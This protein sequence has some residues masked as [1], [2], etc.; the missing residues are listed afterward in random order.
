MKVFF[1][2]LKREGVIANNPASY[3]ES[4]K[5]WQ[6]LPAVLTEEEM[7]NILTQPNCHSAKGCRDRAILELLYSSGVRI[8]ELCGL[9]ICDVDDEYI[10]VYGKGGKERLVPIGQNALGAIDHY[11]LHYRCRYD[12]DQE[13]HLFLTQRGS[14]IDRFAMWRMVKSYALKAGITKNISPHTFRHSFATHLLDH[15]ADLRVIQELLGHSSINSTDRYTHVSRAQLQ[16]AFQ[17]FHPRC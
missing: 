17:A 13:Q 1:R 12:S 3:L 4:P 8:S 6:A 16:Q 14:P 11:L 7:E 15:G 9:K 10:K 5:L 2:F